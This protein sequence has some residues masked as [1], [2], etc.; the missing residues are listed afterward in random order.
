MT[1]HLKLLVVVLMSVLTIATT[2]K[3][4]DI[5]ISGFA[6]FVAGMTTSSDDSLYG[7][8]DD[9]DFAE[10]SLLGLQLSKD[11]GEGWGVTTQLL[12]RGSEEWDIGVTWAF[13]SY[14]TDNSRW[15]FGRQRAPFYLYSDF[16]D[17]SYAYHWIEPPRGVYS[18]PFDSIDGIGYIHNSTVGDFDSTIHATFGRN[19]ET[20]PLSG[21]QL[22]S[23]FDEFFSIAWALTQ[24]EYTIR[25]SYAQAGRMN[26]QTPS[27]LGQLVGGWQQAGFS[28]VSSNLAIDDD[29]GAFA[30]VAF[31]AD[32]ED[33]IFVSEYTEVMPGDNI[34]SDN[35]SFFASL[36]YRANVG[37]FHI[38]YGMDESNSDYGILQNVP[39]GLDP[40]LD[41][42]YAATTGALA[43]QEEDASYIT[44][45]FKKDFDTTVSLKVE[46][47]AFS[48]DL[49]GRNDPN[50]I[51]I[52]LVTIF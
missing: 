44:L 36:G 50:L 28:D 51:R 11:L 29:K 4:D 41:F 27:D 2:L 22:S 39:L 40:G 15:L 32:F 18:L 43:G 17:V 46:Y 38:T 52:A 16:L 24:N 6:S 23:D 47:T 13:A 35:E 25:F 20:V 42:L 9:I 37:M 3:A 34:F 31:I 45:G 30:G 10:G 49:P 5:Q 19:Q 33:F 14:T 1:R 26:I 8:N 48:N 21:E 7:F 12:S